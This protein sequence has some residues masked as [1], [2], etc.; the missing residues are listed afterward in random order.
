MSIWICSESLNDVRC[1]AV[2]NSIHVARPMMMLDPY[3][4]IASAFNN[5]FPRSKR[6]FLKIALMPIS[7]HGLNC[8]LMLSILK[9]M[10]PCLGASKYFQGGGNPQNNFFFF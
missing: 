3:I 2:V 5:Q 9:T 8:L 10:G 1:L 6:N 7:S 4:C